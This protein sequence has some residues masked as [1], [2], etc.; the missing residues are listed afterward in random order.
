METEKLALLALCVILIAL[1]KAMA[2]L[3]EERGGKDTWHRKWDTEIGK[4]G[5]LV[6]KPSERK[7]YYLWLYKP[8]FQERF[9]YSSTILV[10][11]TDHWHSWNTLRHAST[12]MAISI[13]SPAPIIT[14]L[15]TYTLFSITFH[16]IYTKLKR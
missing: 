3:I 13:F 4:I 11:L 12:F 5:K 8:I 7:W 10:G 14:F 15:S 16:Y 1:S 9:P 2:D 6:F